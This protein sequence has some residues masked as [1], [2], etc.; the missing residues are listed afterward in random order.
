MTRT[1]ALLAVVAAALCIAGLVSWL[2]MQ[3]LKQKVAE[4][5]SGNSV[6]IVVAAADIPVG[7]KLTPPHLKSTLWPK[8]SL[9]AGHA[10]DQQS[11]LGRVTIKPHSSGEP[12]VE[13]RLMPRDKTTGTGLM[14]YIIPPGHR[15]ITVAVNEVAGVAGFLSPNSKVD[16][17]LTTTPQGS[18]D[19]ISKIIL[20][21]VPL[22][23][24]GQATEQKDGKPVVVTT[25]TLDMTPEDSEK[26]VLA[27]SRGSL[28]LLLRGV[29]DGERVETRG[30]T[31]TKVL[32]DARPV[33]AAV[34]ARPRA[35]AP[36][37]QP[38]SGVEIIK[39][40]NRSS[41]QFG[42]EH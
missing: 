39:G 30:A 15:A 9:P 40:A 31:V 22:L 29:T 17:V 34:A 23:A 38:E 13:G 3:F 24:T 42:A 25:V 5:A 21:N 11:V 7:T 14:S 28:Q 16:V 18:N 32:G 4:S 10:L 20:Q 8:N 12:V 36:R 1:K 2:V 33:A 26:I 37:P 35:A 27:A 19:T 6:A 41:K